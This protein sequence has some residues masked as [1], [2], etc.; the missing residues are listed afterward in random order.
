[1]SLTRKMLKGMSL[2]DEQI[3]TIIEAHTETVDALKEER[4]LYKADAEK[5]PAV[6]RELNDLKNKE[7]DGYEQKYNDLKKEYDDYKAAEKAKADNLAKEQA[8]KEL[9][10]E[11]GIAEKRIP[12]IMKVT[13]LKDIT[14]TKEGKLKD[15]DKLTEG[16]K[17]EWSDFV[18]SEQKQGAKTATPPSGSH[19][20]SM[21]KEEI[22][23]IKDT[24]ER[25][26][27]MAENHELFGF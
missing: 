10:K 25:Q 20:G 16:I 15:A 17:E 9:L 7:D 24:S 4:N 12:A 22:M 6:Q 19:S 13:D 2:T 8:Y 26:K 11:A 21:T 18:V 1:M 5:L 14:L 27:A 23:K 3:D